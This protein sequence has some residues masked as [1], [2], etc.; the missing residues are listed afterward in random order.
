[1]NT[2]ALEQ[3]ILS[4]RL[5]RILA[6]G[7]LVN[8]LLILTYNVFYLTAV[9]AATDNA[10]GQS[11]GALRQA[12]HSPV[13]YR[14]AWMSESLSWLVLGGTL[15]IFAGLFARRE[16]IR[17]TY[18]AVCGIGQLIT[19]LGA[20]SLS[21]VSGL[22]TRYLTASPNQQAVLLQLY[23]D[24]QGLTHSAYAVGILLEGA[25]FLLV[26][27]VAWEWRGFPHWLTVWLAIPGLLG[28]LYFVLAATD[29]PTA[30]VFPV[31]ILGSIGLI[32]VYVAVAV[33]FWRP[34]DSVISEPTAS[35][36]V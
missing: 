2:N 15:I 33:R 26:A 20:F 17:A 24:L 27:W 12:I 35:A 13:L 3:D 8:A 29:A 1:M 31:V 14:L 10:L 6:R 28:L 18:I 16:P 34:S 36:A 32:G 22:A 7:S 11:Y 25:G 19:S 21:S 9:S 5:F 4:A 30:L 23:L